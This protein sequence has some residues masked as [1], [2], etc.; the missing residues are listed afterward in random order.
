MHDKKVT[1]CDKHISSR[2]C[3][4]CSVWRSW[5]RRPRKTWPLAT[6]LGCWCWNWVVPG[7]RWSH[8]VGH[9]QA[10]LDTPRSRMPTNTFKVLTLRCCNVS[11]CRFYTTSEWYDVGLRCL[12]STF[13]CGVDGLHGDFICFSAAFCLYASLSYAGMFYVKFWTYD[14]ILWHV[15]YFD[16]T[17]CTVR[18][19]YWSKD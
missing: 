13:A 8:A 12:Y 1:Y 17:S 16:I 14:V 5:C 15:V 10:G 18:A 3:I 11:S 2:K 6:L 19:S 4:F 7:R 9:R